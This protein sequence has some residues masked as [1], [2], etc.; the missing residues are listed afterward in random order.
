MFPTEVLLRAIMNPESLYRALSR[1]SEIDESYKSF[2]G[3]TTHHFWHDREVLNGPIRLEIWTFVQ[4]FPLLALFLSRALVIATAS[5]VVLATFEPSFDFQPL[6]E[7]LSSARSALTA[8]FHRKVES[9]IFSALALRPSSRKDLG[10][11]ERDT[12]V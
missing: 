5:A 6:P 7:T 8:D 9:C 10:F 4:S 2:L 12:R 1:V 11:G 3:V